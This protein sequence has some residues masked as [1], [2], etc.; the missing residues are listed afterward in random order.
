MQAYNLLAG[1][2]LAGLLRSEAEP[3]P[4]GPGDVRVAVRAAALNY[5]DLQFARG[6]YPNTPPHPLVPLSDG[7]GGGPDVSH[8]ARIAGR[9]VLES[10]ATPFLAM[11]AAATLLAI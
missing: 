1:A 7:V 2:G 11:H 10:P 4:L 9:E 3:R 8:V 5:R 6:Q